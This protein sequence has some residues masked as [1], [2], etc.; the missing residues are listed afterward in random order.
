[1]YR[2]FLTLLLMMQSSVIL[3]SDNDTD[4]DD[5]RARNWAQ[6]LAMT[7][8]RNVAVISSQEMQ[9]DRPHFVRDRASENVAQNLLTILEQA[10]KKKVIIDDQNL[11]SGTITTEYRITS[12]PPLTVEQQKLLVGLVLDVTNPE[13]LRTYLDNEYERTRLVQDTFAHISYEALRRY[14]CNQLVRYHSEQT[15]SDFSSMLVRQLEQEDV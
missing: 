5:Y 9:I 13:Q 11:F 2:I 14:I 6:A 4:A 12:N 10:S 7:V 3:P 1:M 15:R 8:A